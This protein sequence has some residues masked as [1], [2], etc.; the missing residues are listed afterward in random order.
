MPA[1]FFTLLPTPTNRWRFLK[2]F[3]RHKGLYQYICIY[4]LPCRL[5]P[6]ISTCRQ[7]FRGSYLQMM[8]IGKLKRPIFTWTFS[9]H[10]LMLI[11]QK[12]K[13]QFLI[14]D[15]RKDEHQ[16][17]ECLMPLGW[18]IFVLTYGRTCFEG[19][20]LDHFVLAYRSAESGSTVLSR[21][22]SLSLTE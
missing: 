15:F 5:P 20:V 13:Y 8:W 2:R 19:L 4:F 18:F 3:A 7:S 10:P 11:G 14:L 22:A 12:C 6:T 9:F 1:N 17:H 21:P 16:K